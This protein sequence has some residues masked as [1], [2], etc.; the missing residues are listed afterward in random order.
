MA[1]QPPAPDPSNPRVKI[2]T[3]AGD[4]VVEL[5]AKKAPISTENFLRYVKENFFEGLIFHRVIRGFVVQ[6]GGLDAQGRQKKGH[7]PIK[8]EIH[9]ELRH[10]NGAL[11]MARTSVPNSAT[12]QF[13]IC[14]GAQKGLDD[15]Y[16]VFGQVREGM[17]VVEKIATT[18][19]DRSERPKTDITIK[20]TTVL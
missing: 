3:T 16:A 14:H 2:E 5:F 1:S 8:L 13:Y 18:P 6:G 9:P 7:A 17:D 19:T 4:M 20:R 12:S 15:N 11:S 10:W